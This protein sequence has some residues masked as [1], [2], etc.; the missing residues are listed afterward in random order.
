MRPVLLLVLASLSLS[1]CKDTDTGTDTDDPGETWTVSGEVSGLAGAGLTLAL[2]DGDPL[3][4][5]ADGAFTFSDALADGAAYAVTVATQ[6]SGPAQTCTVDAGTGTVDGAD[7]T[8][9]AVTCETDAFSVYGTVTGLVSA[10]L[11][12]SH[13]GL[14]EDVVVDPADPSFAFSEQLDGEAWEVVVGGELT[15]PHQQCTLDGADR[16]AGNLDGADAVL[17][18]VCVTDTYDVGGTVSGLDGTVTLAVGEDEV[19]VS[20]DGAVSFALDEGSAYL[21]EI[22]EHP[23]GQTCFVTDGTGTVPVGGDAAAFTVTCEDGRYWPVYAQGTTWLSYVEADGTDRFTAS[24]TDCASDHVWYDECIHAAEVWRVPVLGQTSCEGLT[25]TDTGGTLDWECDGSTNPVQLWSPGIARD[26]RLSGLIDFAAGTWRPMQVTVEREGEGVVYQTDPAVWWD[27]TIIVANDGVAGD[28]HDPS[29]IFIVNDGSEPVTGRYDLTEA[30]ALLV[31]P[32]VVLT[33]DDDGP[34]RLVYIGSY[35]D[36]VWIEGALDANGATGIYGKGDRL[37]LRGV[38]VEGAPWDKAVYLY[39]AEATRLTDLELV[40]NLQIIEG[41]GHMVDG[42]R[43]FAG[44]LQVDGYTGGSVFHDVRISGWGLQLEAPFLRLTHVAGIGLDEGI[45]MRDTAGVLLDVTVAHPWAYGVY[46]QGSSELVLSNTAV[47]NS[48][49]DG[50]RVDNFRGGSYYGVAQDDLVLRNLAATHSAG[51]GFLVWAAYAG[52]GVTG[53]YEGAMVLGN[54]G[55]GDC[56]L[57]PTYVDLGLAA[58]CTGASPLTT[59][60]SLTDSLVGPVTSDA[61]NP[62]GLSGVAEFMPGE[63]LDFE[64]PYRAWALYSADP[65][66]APSGRGACYSWDDS[67]TLYCQMTDVRLQ[68]SDPNLLGVNPLPTGDDVIVQAGGGGFTLTSQADCDAYTLGSV[69]SDPDGTASSGDER[70]VQTF[71]KDAVEV[72]GDWVGND[73]GL[74]ESHETCI[75]SPNIGA[76][77]GHGELV[78]VG[79]LGDTG[80]IVDVRLLG[81]TDEGI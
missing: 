45:R 60:A 71:L 13:T 48:G 68:A 76:Y 63:T 14:S 22:V 54:N 29:D 72:M 33:R 49:E 8:D 47:L 62:S 23:D 39:R 77:Q 15:D 2:N 7:V 25:A 26:G 4:V 1:A 21:V 73:N 59:G 16:A 66:P 67:V 41:R 27:N 38:R 53:T 52:R 28:D 57:N 61:V 42:L 34:D 17:E 35:E 3:A 80:T 75:H 11:V 6:P 12:L 40:G 44:S 37:V 18:V 31:A 79:T 74:C 64:T 43:T 32:G 70:C 69:Y 30:Q 36:G 65:Y 5:D 19:D 20:A 24:G 51:Y 58:D 9:I 56:S 81:W 55:D 10:G 46:I 50:F 78:E